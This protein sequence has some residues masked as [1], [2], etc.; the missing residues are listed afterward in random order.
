M[1]TSLSVQETVPLAVLDLGLLFI[2]SFS[3]HT[4]FAVEFESMC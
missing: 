3:P 1:P 2:A 4:I